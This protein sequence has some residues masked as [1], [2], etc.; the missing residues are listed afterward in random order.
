MSARLLS[1][2]RPSRVFAGWVRARSLGRDHVLARWLRRPVADG[3]PAEQTLRPAA[4]TPVADA[5]PPVSPDQAEPPAVT[6]AD[7]LGDPLQADPVAPPDD[8]FPAD[9]E[10][11]TGGALP[12]GGH[13]DAGMADGA[14]SVGEPQ[15]TAPP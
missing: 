6:T 5:A 10:H 1:F 14:V 11:G 7:P 8:P 13:G 15:T 9:G 12:S 2:L 3:G 4:Q